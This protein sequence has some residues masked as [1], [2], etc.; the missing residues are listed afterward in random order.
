MAAR[1]Q[2]GRV[3]SGNME[4]NQNKISQPDRSGAS[5]VQVEI[6]VVLAEIKGREKCGW[7]FRMKVCR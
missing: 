2:M 3:A 5:R 1:D 6:V 7:S 4:I